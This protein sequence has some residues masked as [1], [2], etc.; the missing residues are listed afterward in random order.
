[1]EHPIF[2]SFAATPSEATGAHI[3]DFLGGRTRVSYKKGWERHAPAEGRTVQ[4]KPPMHNEHYFDWIATLMAVK[5]AEGVFRMAELG[6]G[7]APWLI[8]GAL[9]AR[10]NDTITDTE[11][12]A[13]EADPTHFE[14]I[15]EHFTDNGLDPDTHQ[16]LFGAAS[17]EPGVLRF[18]VIENPDEDY[19][20]SLRA[21]KGNIPVIEV[22]AYTMAEILEHFT[23]PLD[24]LH[25]DIQGAEYDLLPGAMQLLGQSVKQIMIGT[26][27]ADE[28]H[29]ALA[30]TFRANGWT[31]VMNFPR[32]ATSKTEFGDVAFGDGFLLYSNPRF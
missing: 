1:M 4:P 6:A 28:R 21:A 15:N 8:R 31:E 16:I 25:V 7:W 10:Q 22:R 23:G 11:L 18:P 26:H 27:L 30:E 13:V 5:K 32:N 3:F 19:G 29:E 12:L 20:A 9:A 14:W 24:F 2:E 17:G